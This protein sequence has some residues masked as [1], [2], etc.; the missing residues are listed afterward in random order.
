MR[1][2]ICGQSS[3]PKKRFSFWK[4]EKNSPFEG[5]GGFPIKQLWRF[6][7]KGKSPKR[8]NRYLFTLLAKL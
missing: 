4:P 7:E 2:N 8:E 6:P 5:Y 3:E 1:Y